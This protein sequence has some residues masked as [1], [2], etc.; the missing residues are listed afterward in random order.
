MIPKKIHYCWFG[1]NELPE[2]ALK[3]I[4]SW[5]K[6]CPD[7]KIIQWD[8]SN[9]DVTKNAYMNE[10]YKA[11]KWAFVSDY[12]R[13][14]IIYNEGGIYLDT[15]VE[16]LKNLD[17]FLNDKMFCGFE[18]N[19][20]SEKERF[21]AFG[22]GF[23]AESRHSVLKDLLDL[24]EK[25]NFYN[26]DGSMNLIPCPEYQTKILIE[27]GLLT[28]NNKTQKLSDCVVYSDDYFCPKDGQTGCLLITDNS[29]SIHHYS[30]TWFDDKHRKFNERRQNILKKYGFEKGKKILNSKVI[31]FYLNLRYFGIKQTL[32]KITSNN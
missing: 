1:G 18:K 4:E 6:F 13:L 9:Y 26:S 20:L 2:D 14:D 3:C 19:L 29:V 30:A 11:K 28:L 15:D 25:L 23:G 31:K 10:A 8:E 32:K 24:Y 17:K 22:L 5:K 27:H 7:Y 16:L 21:V 12:A